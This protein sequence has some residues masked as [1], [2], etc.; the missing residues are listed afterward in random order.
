MH[1]DDMPQDPFNNDPQLPDPDLVK[2]QQAMEQS[3]KIAE[4][5]ALNMAKFYNTLVA[6]E[7]PEDL[8]RTLT[9]RLNHAVT[10]TFYPQ[11]GNIF[12]LGGQGGGAGE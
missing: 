6:N 10:S 1:D 8:A 9:E 5:M 2:K 7:V 3:R 12:G 11:M 4:E